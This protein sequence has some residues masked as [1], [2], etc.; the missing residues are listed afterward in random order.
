MKKKCWFFKISAVEFFNEVNSLP[1]RER[2]KWVTQL[3]EDLIK[4]EKIQTS[5]GKRLIKDANS[6]FEKAMEFGKLGGR[7]PKGTVSESKA[8]N[9]NQNQNNKLADQLFEIRQ[10]RD[11]AVSWFEAQHTDFI[12]YYLSLWGGKCQPGST[13]YGSNCLKLHELETSEVQNERQ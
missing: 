8:N 7:P 10:K 2:G 13:N 6:R 12:R 4:G 3:A 5:F 11:A 9:Q 1:M